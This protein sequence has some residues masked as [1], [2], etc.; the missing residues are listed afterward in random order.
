MGWH[1]SGVTEEK[2]NLFR[3]CGEFELP[4]FESIK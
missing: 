4:E 3:F 2:G 1:P